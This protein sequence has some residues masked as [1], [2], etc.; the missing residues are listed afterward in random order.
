MGLFVGTFFYP[1]ISPTKR[2]R[3]VMWGF[4][5]VALPFAILLYVVLIRNF[6]TGDPYSGKPS[7]FQLKGSLTWQA[8]CSWCRYLSC[9]PTSA[10]NYC[11][12]YVLFLSLFIR[13]LDST[14]S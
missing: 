3:L 14:F 10:N 11:K 2:H 9:I 13:P 7:F 5:L 12:G 6:Y 8:A 1:V 4:R